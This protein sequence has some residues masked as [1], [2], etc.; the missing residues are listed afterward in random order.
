MTPR[1]SC[2]Y[3]AHG[4]ASHREDDRDDRSIQVS[5]SDLPRFRRI[6][7]FEQDMVTLKNASRIDEIDPVLRDRRLPLRLVPFEQQRSTPEM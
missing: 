1:L 7:S 5:N 4:L 2:R 3:E 6:V